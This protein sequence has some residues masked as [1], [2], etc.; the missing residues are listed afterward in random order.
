M[1][2]NK[3]SDIARALSSRY[4]ITLRE[5]TAFINTMVDIINEALQYEKLIKIKGLG[6]F[7]LTAVSARESIDVTTG[8]RIN[9]EGRDK[10]TFTPEPTLRDR[11][12]APF[13]QFDTFVIND[14][15][16]FSEID[17]RYQET[18]QD[19]DDE[20]TTTTPN[21]SEIKEPAEQVGTSEQ[22]EMSVPVVEVSMMNEDTEGKEKDVSQKDTTASVLPLIEKSGESAVSHTSDAETPDADT[23]SAEAP[24]S[25]THSVEA[26]EVEAPSSE[27]HSVEASE[28]EAPE[29]E[30]PSAGASEG[31]SLIAMQ[32]QIDKLRGDYENAEEHSHQQRRR[33]SILLTAFALTIVFA[34]GG[35]VY[36]TSQLHQK[37]KL[38]SALLEKQLEKATEKSSPLEATTQGI[39]NTTDSVAADT[40][41]NSSDSTAAVTPS[42]PQEETVAPASSAVDYDSD[43]RIRLGAY[44]IVGIDRKVTVVRGQTFK[45]ISKA[46]LGE[47]MECY[48]EAVNPGITSVKEGDTLNI[49]KLEL[50]K[51]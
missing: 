21:T 25:E 8:E 46:H 50:K 26:P 48:M 45:M 43:P 18:S 27:T 19:S 3:T 28:V 33:F 41:S 17:K 36:L 22:A 14:G 34:L 2:T 42:Q 24:S 38:I 49:P 15:V 7:K 13:V 51:K 29:V 35:M 39:I 40:L 23:S 12:N 30:A 44:R 31:V 20:Q 9:I 6:T 4:D 1:K 11:V 47:G 32:Q 5:A 37:D 16:D 10:I